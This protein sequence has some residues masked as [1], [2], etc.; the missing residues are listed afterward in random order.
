MSDNGS[1][2]EQSP[3]SEKKRKPWFFIGI[4]G[5]IIV[6]AM[7]DNVGAGVAIGISFWMLSGLFDKK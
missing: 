7:F 4:V 1:G 2:R 5:G 6:G 3:G